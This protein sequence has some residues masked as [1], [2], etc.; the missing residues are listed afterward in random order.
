MKP[1]RL[2]LGRVAGS[3]LSLRPD[4]CHCVRSYTWQRTPTPKMDEA[5]ASACSPA[6]SISPMTPRTL[7]SHSMPHDL[8]LPTTALRGT[9]E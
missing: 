6:T 5:I 2:R 1:Y 4:T 3:T 8:P 7:L 9:I